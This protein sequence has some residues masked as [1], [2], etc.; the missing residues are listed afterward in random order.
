VP[1]GNARERAYAKDALVADTVRPVRR[2]AE[3]AGITPAA[4]ADRLAERRLAAAGA[5][6]I[7]TFG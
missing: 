2:T 7:P 3:A 1:G 6:T 5:H 4:A